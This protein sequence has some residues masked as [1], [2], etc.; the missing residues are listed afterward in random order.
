MTY[1]PD[2]WMQVSC[3]IVKCMLL[4]RIMTKIKRID[5]VTVLMQMNIVLQKEISIHNIVITRHQFKFDVG[6]GVT[7]L[8]EIL[9][10]AIITTMK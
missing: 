6:E 4:F 3:H 8:T 9:P 5:C 2:A 1:Q 10:V 7:Q